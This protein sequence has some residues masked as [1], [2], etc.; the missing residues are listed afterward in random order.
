MHR[1]LKESLAQQLACSNR[2]IHKIKLDR[3]KSEFIASCDLNRSYFI[4]GGTGATGQL[5]STFLMRYSSPH[6]LM[7]RFGRT[8][9]MLRQHQYSDSVVSF[10]QS[11]VHTNIQINRYAVDSLCFIHAAGCTSDALLLR[12]TPARIREVFAPKVLTIDADLYSS[13]PLLSAIF[14]SSITARIGSPGQANYSCANS[15]LDTLA[16][17]EHT[18]GRPVCSV[19]WGAWGKVGMAIRNKYID[20][21][22]YTSPSPRDRG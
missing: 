3:N 1:C 5:T 17:F 11:Y 8:N 21:L 4:M 2:K 9:C 14:F 15:A 13:K 20:C 7:S 22:L 6:T 10:V 19:Q 12:Q 18:A 16:Q